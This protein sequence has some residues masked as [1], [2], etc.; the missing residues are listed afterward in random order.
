MRAGKE[1]AGLSLSG[2]GRQQGLG[3]A[4]RGKQGGESR[5]RRK[6][7]SGWGGGEDPR[8]PSHDG[9]PRREADLLGKTT[10]SGALRTLWVHI[11][12]RQLHP[13]AWNPGLSSEDS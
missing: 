5:E 4:W 1:G 7:A 13:G 8:H 3:G 10:R 6:V 11:V 12:N 2:T 9:E